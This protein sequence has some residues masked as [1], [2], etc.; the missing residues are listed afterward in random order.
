MRPVGSKYLL[1]EPIGRGATGTVWRARQRETA[2]AEAAVPGR[3]GETVAIKVLKEEL[4]NDA[5][6]V[7]RSARETFA[8]LGAQVLVRR[9]DQELNATG[10]NSTRTRAPLS[11]LTEQERAVA[12]LVAAG[13]SN[14]QVAEQ[15]FLS[16]KTIQYHL[17]RVY[18]K[19]GIRSR[20]ELAAYLHELDR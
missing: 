4:A 14:R 3:P 19:F 12:R 13:G 6:I 20:T 18:A 2:G 16:V 8:T 7:M 11:E 9:C 5:D 1:E 17:T 15:L 10:V